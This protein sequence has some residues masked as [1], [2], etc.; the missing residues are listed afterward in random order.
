MTYQDEDENNFAC[1]AFDHT[2]SIREVAM[3]LAD[4]TDPAVPIAKHLS[5]SGTPGHA[6]AEV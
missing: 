4:D 1:A 6:A 3:Q 2:L 5:C